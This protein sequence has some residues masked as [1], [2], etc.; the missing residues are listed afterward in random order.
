M[1]LT[2]QPSLSTKVFSFLSW[3]TIAIGFGLIAVVIYWLFVPSV[4]ITFEKPFKVEQK[5]VKSGGY[6]FYEVKYCKYTKI[7]PEISKTFV[8][9]I[10]YTIAPA[11]AVENPLGCH[12][13]RVQQY[14]PKAI[15]VGKYYIDITYHYQL[16]P[17]RHHDV[18]V[19]TEEFTVTNGVK[20]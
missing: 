4:P 3:A 15:P 11:P 17:L 7:I 18:T 16:N 5:E 2:T 8:D 12:T 20:N 13:N 6:L 19:Q 10:L 1:D 9:G 14:I